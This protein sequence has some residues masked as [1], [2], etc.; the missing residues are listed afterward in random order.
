MNLPF[1]WFDIVLPVVLIFGIQRGR[2]HGMSQE[3]LLVM[4]W[5]AIIIVGGLFYQTLGDTIEASSA[6]SHLA[7]Y[8]L[9]YFSIA[10][11]IGIAFMAITKVSHGKLVGSDIFGSGEYYLGMMAGLVRYTCIVIFALSFLNSRLYTDKEVSDELKFQNDV[12]GSNF[13][14]TGYTF[15]SMVFEK[16]FMGP[17]IRKGLSFLLIKSTVTEEKG[18]KRRPADTL[19]E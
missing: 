5:L 6:L 9:A 7:S 15:Q 19:P 3:L 16:S 17:Y 4:K 8:R 18:L 13:F 11:T 1:N 14:P 12:Y 10:L 2:K